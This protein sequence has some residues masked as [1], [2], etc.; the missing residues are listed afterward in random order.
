MSCS[1]Y[2]VDYGDKVKVG[3]TQNLQ[4][5][6]RAL[7]TGAGTPIKRYF[8][9]SAFPS[10]ETAVLR[11]LNAYKVIGEYFSCSFS[12]AISAVLKF[13]AVYGADNKG[14]IYAPELKRQIKACYKFNETTQAKVAEKLGISP[15]L[16]YKKMQA[17]FFPCEDLALLLSTVDITKNPFWA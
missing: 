16:V 3:R 7:E 17:E 9:I 5:R 2:A 12:T 4:K 1:I 11:E 10:L 13:S 6:I 8:F 14:Y 15:Q